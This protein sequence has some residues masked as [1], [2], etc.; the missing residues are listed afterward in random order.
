MAPP[1][2]NRGIPIQ[3]EYFWSARQAILHLHVSRGPHGWRLYKFYLKKLVSL[4]NYLISA[5]LCLPERT[6]VADN[7]MRVGFVPRVSS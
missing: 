4:C 5:K 7:D 6:D 3:L 2:S 1:K